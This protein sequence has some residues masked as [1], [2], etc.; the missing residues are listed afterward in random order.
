MDYG[1]ESV[2]NDETLKNLSP[3]GLGY[4]QGYGIEKPKPISE[5]V[6][7]GRPLNVVT[8][9]ASHKRLAQHYSARLPGTAFGEPFIDK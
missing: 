8:K 7:P 2:E 1:L 5:L 9:S 4:A 3:L 6:R